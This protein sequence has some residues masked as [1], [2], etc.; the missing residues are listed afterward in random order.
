M[1]SIDWSAAANYW[2]DRE[3]DEVRLPEGELTAKIGNFITRHKVC[4][5]AAAGNGIVRNTPVEYIYAEHDFWV[6]SEG[7]LKF[8]A[9][10][11]S[12]NVCL[13]IYDDDPSFG[14][15]AGLQVTGV[16][17][18]LEPFGDSYKHACDLRN[19]PFERLKNLPSVMNV[20]RIFPLRYDY[21]NGSL[22]KRGFSPRQHLELRGVSRGPNSEANETP[23]GVFPSLQ[24]AVCLLVIRW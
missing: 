21:L 14:S 18:V 2:L 19:L 20:I 17:K 7:G 12:P 9:L 13:A 4:A 22:K 8:K 3:T 6:F 1:A 5:L 15:L 16:A 24:L 11:D 10:R 23:V